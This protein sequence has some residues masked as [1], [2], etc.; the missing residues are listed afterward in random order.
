M[1]DLF[2]SA[3]ERV[4]AYREFLASHRVEVDRVRDLAGF[5]GLPATTKQNYYQ[6]YE[7]PS[8]C[9][10]G[11]LEDSDMLAVSSGS[12]GE[13]A[14][15]PRFVADEFGTARR[16]EQV[17][18][19]AFGV[20]AR[21]TLAVICFALGTWVGG[22][23]S[24]AACRHLAA[25]GYPITLLTPGN[26]P[27]EVLRGV[28]AAAPYF[29]QL[30]LLGYPP[31]LKD[32]LDLGA[33]NGLEWRRFRPHLLMA[34]EVFSESW[35][36]RMCQTL[37]VCDPAT[38]TA[39]LYGTADG[40]VLAN[41]TPTS[42]RIRRVLAARPDLALELFGQA[43]LPTLCQYDPEHRFFE[44]DSGRLLFSGD[45]GVP[46]L[47]YDILDRGGVIPYAQMLAFLDKQRLDTASLTADALEQPFVFVFGR[48]SFAVSYYGANVYPENIAVGLEQPEFFSHVT[49]KFVI[50]VLEDEKLDARLKIS[51]EL[52]AEG[53]HDA[54][55]A[56]RLAQSIVEH[57]RHVN[58]EFR[59][60]VPPARQV[61]DVTLL[62]LGDPGSFPRGVKHRYTR[63]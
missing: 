12:T 49:G 38:A 61:V 50:E 23:Y 21:P 3:A 29:E 1:L 51:V 27:E 44:E 15:W 25:K 31:F 11:K 37:G 52:V 2:Y 35:R 8:L 45:G 19:G 63:H 54:D 36:D 18:V 41:E 47:R 59:N 6:R 39:S 14:L 33:R 56:S 60:Y 10:D 30:V 58:S 34:G 55:L 42:V 5:R 26:N 53:R 17:L 22:M 46:L 20:D 48:S 40:G 9:W 62:P 57:L 28:N 4:P 16:F 32:V 13:P 43:R 24:A 7:L